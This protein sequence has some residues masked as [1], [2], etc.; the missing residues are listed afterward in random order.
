VFITIRGQS[1]VCNS[2]SK[3][4]SYVIMLWEEGQN[5]TWTS[6]VL[7][8]VLMQQVRTDVARAIWYRGNDN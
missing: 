3:N 7:K 6:L 5:K 4:D 1:G 8:M 2:I